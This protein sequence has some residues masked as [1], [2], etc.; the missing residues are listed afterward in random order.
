MD[1][2]PDH[3]MYLGDVYQNGTDEEFRKNYEPNF[4]AI[5]EITWPICGN[6]CWGQGRGSC[7]G[8][9]KYWNGLPNWYSPGI[10]EG[11]LVL[12]LDSE[13]ECHQGT[14][15]WQFVYE[16]VETWNGPIIA[17]IH[18]PRWSAGT[19]KDH[20]DQPQVEPLY[21][22]MSKRPCLVL[23]GHD[24]NLQV[25]KLQGKMQ[26]LVVGSGGHE[27]HRINKND[28]RLQWGTHKHFGAV[29]MQLTGDHCD[30]AFH[31]EKGL[32]IY[33]SRFNRDGSTGEFGD[34]NWKKVF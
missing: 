3:F 12:M 6:H 7:E 5:K 31:T 26:Q 25:M 29:R 4:G 10:I 27:L 16:Q 24:H 2:S 32:P 33:R 20:G 21:D 11:W 17:C 28:P 15:Q 30:F 8:W 13:L 22:L 14:P 9:K 34:G 23:S 19:N 1:D 18:H